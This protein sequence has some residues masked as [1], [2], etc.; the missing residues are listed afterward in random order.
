MR[1]G[2]L[3][4]Y[5][6]G[7]PIANLVHYGHI[8]PPLYNLSNIAVDMP[9][10]LSYGGRDALSS[11]HDVQHLLDHFKFHDVDKLSV[12]FIKDYAHLDFIMAVNAN[13]I[14]YNAILSFFKHHQPWKR[15]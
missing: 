10:F 4:K 12:Q 5:D 9:V 13:D 8:N 15:T 2:V 3:A 11:V 6:Y 14:V 1:D 7:N